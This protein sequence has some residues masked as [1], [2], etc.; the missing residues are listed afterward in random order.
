MALGKL[1]CE[2]VASG[3]LESQCFL[4]PCL[5]EERSLACPLIE[6]LLG[7]FPFEPALVAVT[8]RL[9]VAV[10]VAMDRSVAAARKLVTAVDS[11][12]SSS[13]NG[14]LFG[15]GIPTELQAADLASSDT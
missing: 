6:K 4:D 9:A 11:L 7:L 15:T 13:A 12:A 8:D 5:S 1:D 14:W 2:R 3:K 10:A